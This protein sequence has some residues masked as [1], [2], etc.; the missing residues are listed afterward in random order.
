YRRLLQC[1]AAP[2][3]SSTFLRG[4]VCIYRTTRERR[5]LPS[6]ILHAPRTSF[7]RRFV[8]RA[9]RAYCPLQPSL[10]N[11]ME[12]QGVRQSKSVLMTHRGSR[13]SVH[14]LPACRRLGQSVLA[15]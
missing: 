13:T 11:L 9:C 2:S 15:K 14:V 5:N 3:A 12:H 7:H 8:V 4:T 6:A 10:L 1:G